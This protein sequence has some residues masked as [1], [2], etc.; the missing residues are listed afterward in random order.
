M[1]LRSAFA[2]TAAVAATLA[3]V[4]TTTAGAASP[5]PDAYDRALA[6]RLG[7][8]VGTFQAVAAK[9][10]N[11]SQ[12]QK[13]LKTCAPFNKSA[14]QAFAAAFALLPAL[15]I[16]V[17]NQYKP[18]LTNLHDMLAG[19]NPHASLFRQWSSAEAQTFGLILQFDNH[20]KKIDYCRAAKVLTS[21]TS[22]AQD[23]RNVLGI[24]PSVI[25]KL[26]ESGTSKASTTL[27]RLNPQMR[28]FFVAAGLTTKSAKALTT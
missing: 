27:K 28:A 26:Y 10:S 14:S 6:A 18:Q 9:S 17:V 11:D 21:K 16:D 1:P 12:V 23:I 15:L 25:A 22:T 24:D 2:L 13:A 8:A 5:R 3:A 19:M 20:G 4:G 7:A